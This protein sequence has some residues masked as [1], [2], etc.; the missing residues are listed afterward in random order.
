[1]SAEVIL[2]IIAGLFALALLGLVVSLLVVWVQ[3]SEEKGSGEEEQ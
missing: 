3:R 2:R 1:M